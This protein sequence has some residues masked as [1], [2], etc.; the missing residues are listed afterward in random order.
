M[1]G[2][3]G[4]GALN[5]SRS[6]SPCGAA[7]FLRL[8]AACE[9]SRPAIDSGGAEQTRELLGGARRRRRREAGIDLGR[10][11]LENGHR[12][13]TGEL[14]AVGLPAGDGGGDDAEV[15]VANVEGE[16]GGSA[17]RARR[18]ELAAAPERLESVV[19]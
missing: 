16:G 4:R 15:P 12:Q 1:S 13:R 7:T 2:A 14:I 17:Y 9:P 8:A 10:Q 5:T 18:D 3:R 6:D 11:Q 19:A